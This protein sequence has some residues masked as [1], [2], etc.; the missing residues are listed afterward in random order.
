MRYYSQPEQLAMFLIHNMHK[1]ILPGK[2]TGVE[3]SCT[4]CFLKGEVRHLKMHKRAVSIHSYRV[5]E[6]PSELFQLIKEA[7]SNQKS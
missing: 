3:G 2:Y 4:Q 7:E 1:S 6:Q 5:I